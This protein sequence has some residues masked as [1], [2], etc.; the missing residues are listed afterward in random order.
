MSLTLIASQKLNI[1]N[2]LFWTA[3]ACG[4]MGYLQYRSLIEKCLFPLKGMEGIKLKHLPSF[5]RTTDADDLMV[6]FAKGK[7]ENARD[8]SALLFDTIDDLEHEAL[9]ALSPTYPPIFA[10]GPLQLLLSHVPPEDALSP[11]KSTCGKNKFASDLANSK[12]RI[13]WVMRPDLIIGE[14]PLSLRILFSKP[15]KGVWWQVG[16]HKNRF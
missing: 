6:N 3:S 8:A 9:E 11:I 16:A 5:I 7:V 2:V 13:L 1:P 15:R 14:S 10:I 12:M 4:F